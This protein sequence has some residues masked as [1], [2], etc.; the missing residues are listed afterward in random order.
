ME[1]KVVK[2]PHNE[3]PASLLAKNRDLSSLVEEAQDI[4]AFFIATIGD[5]FAKK[6]LQEKIRPAVG[7]ISLFSGL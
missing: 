1:L 6:N 5:N 4:F 2:L 7:I 3:D